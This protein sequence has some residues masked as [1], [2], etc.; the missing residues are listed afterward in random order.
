MSFL[1]IT[2]VVLIA[3]GLGMLAL[4]KPRGPKISS[5]L[6]PPPGFPEVERRAVHAIATS[7][8]WNRLM[9]PQGFKA[10]PNDSADAVMMLMASVGPTEVPSVPRGLQISSTPS[11]E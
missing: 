9:E 4:F 5:T 2:G 10:P 3:V 11:G 1:I 6:P 7:R 8:A